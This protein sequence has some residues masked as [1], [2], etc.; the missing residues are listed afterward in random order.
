MAEPDEPDMGEWVREHAQLPDVINHGRG[1][2]LDECRD[3]FRRADR[4]TD[5]R[6]S[7]HLDDILGLILV[8]MEHV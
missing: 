1:F 4:D 6:D 7:L 8:H 5:T 2:G 3:E